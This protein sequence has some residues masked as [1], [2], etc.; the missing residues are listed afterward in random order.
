MDLN[1]P[2]THLHEISDKINPFFNNSKIFVKL[3][4][5]NPTKS[6]KD[7]MIAYIIKNLGNISKDTI[8]VTASSGNTGS[9]LS[10][11]CKEEGYKCIVVTNDKCSDEK[12]KDCKKY[13]AKVIIKDSKAKPDS[14]DHYQNFAKNLCLKNE[15][16]YDIDQYSNPKNSESY[17]NTLGPEIWEQTEGNITHFV[18]GGSTCGTI[19][20]VGKYL[21]EKNSNI[22][23]ILADPVGSSISNF[24]L[25]RENPSKLASYVVEGVG[26]D[27]NPSLLDRNLIDKVYQVSDIEAITMCHNLLKEQN[28]FLGGSS[29]LNISASCRLASDLAHES[30][31][32]IVTIGCD[33]G[34]KYNSKIFNQSWLKSN[35][36]FI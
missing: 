25:G 12:I 3:E 34:E 33:S 28:L 24:V 31:S 22:S 17:Y 1:L 35:N 15:F 6:I 23:I 11:I 32:L 27:S 13:G 21:K 7:R 14:D 29:G 36:I 9:S 8:F 16:Y 18:A 4:S 20:G 26:K 10:Y 2:E 19:M 5:Q 30:D